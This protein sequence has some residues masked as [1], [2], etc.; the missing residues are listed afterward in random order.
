MELLVELDEEEF[1]ISL[2]AGPTLSDLCEISIKVK[3][4]GTLV[5]GNY[6][7]DTNDR[8]E[9]AAKFSL[10]EEGDVLT[11]GEFRWDKKAGNYAL[12][13][14]DAYDEAITLEGTLKVS[15]QQIA[16]T[17]GRIAVGGDALELQIELTLKASDQKPA[18]P[19][20]YTDLLTMSQGEIEDLTADLAA[21]LMNMVYALDPDVLGV[22]SSLFFGF[23]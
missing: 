23:V 10:R 12:T 9:Y 2:L 11:S 7:V 3:V 8:A 21:E 6:R 5:R 4:D 14:R 13:V 17:L 16:L 15:D 1:E 19:E 22:L 18:T 20:E